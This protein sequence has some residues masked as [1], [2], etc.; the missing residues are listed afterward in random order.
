MVAARL[1]D[2]EETAGIV[3]L[4]FRHALGGGYGGQQTQLVS[5]RI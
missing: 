1:G 2:G 4:V 5:G 3:I